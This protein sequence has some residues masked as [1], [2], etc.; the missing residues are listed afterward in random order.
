MPIP[1][2]EDDDDDDDED[3]EE[4]NVVLDD[5]KRNGVNAHSGLVPVGIEEK[6]E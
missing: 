5:A 2:E 4:D 1:E 3:E 6:G